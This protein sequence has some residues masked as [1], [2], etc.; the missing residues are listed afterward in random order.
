MIP[1]G[2][3]GSPEVRANTTLCETACAAEFQRLRALM[4]HSSA[5][6]AAR[7]SIR[8]ASEPHPGS[9]SAIPTGRSPVIIGSIHSAR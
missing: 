4:T 3:P 5:S 8:V 2:S 1:S 6:G 7:A 9:V